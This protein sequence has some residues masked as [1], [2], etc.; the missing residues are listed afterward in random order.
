MGAVGST[1]YSEKS[2]G[3]N[4]SGPV[5]VGLAA[6]PWEETEMGKGPG[7]VPP[8]GATWSLGLVSINVRNNLFFLL[9][10]CAKVE[11]PRHWHSM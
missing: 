5:L 2:T 4:K 10:A 9:L 3:S 11:L 1:S 6:T 7:S 8:K